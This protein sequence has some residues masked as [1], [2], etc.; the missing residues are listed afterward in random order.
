MKL[1]S[2]ILQ[3]FIRSHT[4]K[5]LYTVFKKIVIM[6]QV[7][8]KSVPVCIHKMFKLRQGIEI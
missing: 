4:L 7:A 3:L 5:F 8:N 2:V 6:F 1:D